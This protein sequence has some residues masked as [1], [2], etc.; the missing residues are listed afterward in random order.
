MSKQTKNTHSA[1]S[2]V[3]C[4]THSATG[5]A[6]GYR[7]KYNYDLLGQVNSGKKYWADGTPV[8]GQQFEYGFDDIG[9]RKSTTRAESQWRQP[10]AGRL[11][12]P[13]TSTNTPAARCPAA[14]DMLGIAY[15]HQHGDG[16]RHS[17]LPQRRVFPSNATVGAN[18]AP[19]GIR[20]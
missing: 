8:A 17:R 18:N 9:N 4:L 20:R 7:T 10:A 5:P 13:T 11:T 3:S 16:Q 12:R 19:P 15:R 1:P 6:S 2:A 14:V